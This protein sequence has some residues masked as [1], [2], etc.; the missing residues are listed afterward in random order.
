MKHA[1]LALIFAFIAL[2]ACQQGPVVPTA[3]GEVTRPELV[4]LINWDRDPSTVVFRADVVGGDRDAEFFTRNEIPHCTIYG[5]NRVVW[6]TSSA[7]NE[8]DSVA[9]DVVDDEVIRVFIEEIT[10][11]RD[12][13][14]YETGADLITPVEDGSTPVVEQMTLFVNDVLHQ[15]DSLGGW[16]FEY[17]QDI[18]DLCRSLSQSPIEF[19][20]AGGWVSARQVQYDDN[21]PSIFWDPDAFENLDIPALA[22]RGE[23][24]WITGRAAQLIWGV[25]RRGGIDLQFEIDEATYL[26]A[27]EV[28]LVTR[29]SPPAP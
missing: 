15:S 28:P 24:E 19:A 29:D 12:F 16:D 22:E 1:F 9:W 13:Y 23:R 18:L 14:E 21:I 10:I 5:D 6:T 3:I 26:V 17:F 4:G 2:T 27:F 25:L 11:Y 8:N 20:P 7:S